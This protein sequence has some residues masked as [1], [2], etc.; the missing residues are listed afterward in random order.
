MTTATKA[1]AAVR[2]RFFPRT[3][4]PDSDVASS[5]FS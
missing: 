1:S 3:R 4:T 5:K 2:R